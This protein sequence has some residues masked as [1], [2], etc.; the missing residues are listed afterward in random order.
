V[1][2]KKKKNF[3]NDKEKG[4]SLRFKKVEIKI[5]V[6]FDIIVRYLVKLQFTFKNSAF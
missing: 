6:R 3:N 4:L 2:F 5:N 1:G